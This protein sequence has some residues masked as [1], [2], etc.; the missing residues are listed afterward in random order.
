MKREMIDIDEKK[1]DGCGLCVPD[2]PEGALQVIGGKARLVGDLFCDGLGACIG[3]CPQGALSV[4]E[5]EAEPY[6]EKRVMRDNIIPKGGDVIRAHLKHLRDHGAD[7]LLDEAFAVLKEELPE[8]SEEFRRELETPPVFVCPGKKARSL[9]SGESEGSSA[10]AP[11]AGENG[12]SALSH[13]P[14]QMALLNPRSPHFKGSDFVLAADCSAFAMGG[15]H[16][17]ILSGKTLGIACP[18]LDDNAGSYRRK[19]EAL[20]DEAGINTLTVIVMEVPCCG[21][22]SRLAQEAASGASRKV[23]VK[24]VVVSVEGEILRQEWL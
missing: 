4:I 12:G 13:W 1:C 2:C 6:E 3:N 21:G 5:R 8:T 23:P 19:L 10:R 22:L 15:F 7:D 17:E 20:I 18:K 16:G 14:V 24:E 9:G 11:A